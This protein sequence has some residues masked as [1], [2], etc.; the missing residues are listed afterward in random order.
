M[1]I[2][3]IYNILWLGDEKDFLDILQVSAKLQKYSNYDAN[4]GVFCKLVVY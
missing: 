3:W 1:S 2:L 4:N